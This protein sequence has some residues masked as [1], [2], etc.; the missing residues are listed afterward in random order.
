MLHTHEVTGSSPVVSTNLPLEI[1][2]FRAVFF[3]FQNFSAAFHFLNYGLFFD[4][5][6]FCPN[7][8]LPTPF[9]YFG[10]VHVRVDVH[11]GAIIGVTENFLQNFRLDACLDGHGGVDCIPHPP[12]ADFHNGPFRFVSCGEITEMLLHTLMNWFKRLNGTIVYNIGKMQKRSIPQISGSSNLS[13]GALRG[14][15][16]ISSVSTS[17]GNVKAKF[18]LLEELR[19]AGVP[20]SES[21]R[22]KN[23][24][25]ARFSLKAYDGVNLAENSRVYD[26]DF[27]VSLPDMEVVELPELSDL[28]NA[29]NRIDTGKVLSAGMKNARAVG[30]ERDGKTYV[31]NRYTGHELEIDKSTIR[32]GLNGGANR[33]ITNA[34]MGAVIGDIVHNAVPINALYNKAKGVSG[35]YAMVAYSTDTIGRE[36][37]AIVT[38]EQYTGKISGVESFDVVHAV[39]GRQK[40]GSQA[41]TKS[42]GLYPIKATNISISDVLNVV[43]S[44]HQSIL[45]NDVLSHLGEMRNP[46]GEYSNKVKF[47]IKGSERQADLVQLQN[48]NDLLRQ[49]V[50]YWKGQ[51]KRTESVT[52]DKKSVLKAA[53]SL[54]KGYSSTADVEEAPKK[55]G[56]LRG[57]RQL[58]LVPKKADVVLIRFPLGPVRTSPAAPWGG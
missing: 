51:T 43:N 22:V 25:A 40:N 50:E 13:N 7:R 11:G 48:E 2:R 15:A 4:L 36:F 44:T 34:R 58:P 8:D 42:Q 35:T 5:S 21:G 31:T 46:D 26:Y 47:S 14:N 57:G 38:V 16:S 23:D 20:I 33:I 39:S 18:P 37:A 17:P 56:F 29:D 3:Y 54:V 1:S 32:H 27:L 12:V 49:Q 9:Q 45:S 30:M 24:S 19:L 10:E 41:D 28:R 55:I 6:Q 53:R 52:T